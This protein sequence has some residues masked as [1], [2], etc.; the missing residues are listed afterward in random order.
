MKKFQDLKIKIVGNQ[1]QTIEGIE[2]FLPDP[3]KRNINLEADLKARSGQEQYCFEG[4]AVNIGRAKLWTM[5]FG[6]ELK[7]TNI[8]PLDKDQLT[9]DEYNCFLNIFIQG[10]LE[11][12][13]E[14][15]VTKSDVE[16]SDL[17]SAESV[18]KFEAFSGLAN[19]ST[20]YSHPSDEARWFEFILSTALKDEPISHDELTFFL[21]EH[22]WDEQ[23]AYDLSLDYSYGFRAMRH[24]LAGGVQ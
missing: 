10:G 22:G 15:E 19:K 2:K 9:I 16:L 3:W 13:F 12:H 24:A 4:E 20:G 6:D 17:V 23:S 18:K 1:E 14:Y 8:V 21:K 5:P 11:G 7:V